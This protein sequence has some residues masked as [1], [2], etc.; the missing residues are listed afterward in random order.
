MKTQ[1]A[2]HEG[3]SQ[4]G[5]AVSKEAYSGRK[6]VVAPFPYLAVHARRQYHPVHV[7]LL[8]NVTSSTD[9]S[10]SI[11]MWTLSRLLYNGTGHLLN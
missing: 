1:S 8:S 5:V 10:A 4:Q 11:N 2:Q 9:T 3:Y 6:T 7:D